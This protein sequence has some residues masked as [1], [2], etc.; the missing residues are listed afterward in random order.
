[1]SF[2]SINSDNKS[3]EAIWSYN[4]VVSSFPF[5]LLLVAPE[6]V[7]TLQTFPLYNLKAHL[8]F[9]CHLCSVRHRG[10][11]C[12]FRRRRRAV[13]W[14]CSCVDSMMG[15]IVNGLERMLPQPVQKQVSRRSTSPLTCVR[16]KDPLHWP[17]ILFVPSRRTRAATRCR[18]V[19]TTHVWTCT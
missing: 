12:S 10:S 8:A 1:M 18:T 5:M 19:S 11:G 6:N 7:E 16:W 14:R 3:G 4:F 2:S 9:P 17:W 13:F 15:W